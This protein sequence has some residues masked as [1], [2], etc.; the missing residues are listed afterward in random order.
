ML[1]RFF[2]FIVGALLIAPFM[3]NPSWAQE[4]EA[5]VPTVLVTGSNRGIGYEFARQYAEQ[6]WKVIATCRKPADATKLQ[7]LAEQYPNLTIEALDVTD[8]EQID[9]LAAKYEGQPIDVL[10]NNA[11]I[12]GGGENQFFGKFNY[13]V[14]QGVI[15]VNVIGPLK[16]AEAFV[17]HV[18]ASKQKK[19]MSVSSSQGSIAQVRVPMLYF[20]RASKSALNM[21]MTN[22]AKQ[23]RGK[24]IIVGLVAPGATD[25][26]FMKGVT[27]PLGDPKDRVAG[28]MESIDNFTLE[29]TGGYIEWT[30]KELPW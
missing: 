10:L 13:D 2:L 23:L 15:D 20:Y 14:F 24:K 18:A 6:G 16:M 1:R 29:K 4:A 7:A 9:S 5:S 3:H 11:G 22:L 25:T 27:I 28:M 30:Q 19:I 8:H 12:S 17:D 26:D 21:V